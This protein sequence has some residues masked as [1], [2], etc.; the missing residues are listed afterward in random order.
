MQEVC[1]SGDGKTPSARSASQE[2]WEAGAEIEQA[3]RSCMDML[4][5][6]SRPGG[7]GQASMLPTASRSRESEFVT[8]GMRSPLVLALR[9]LLVLIGLHLLSPDPQTPPVHIPE[10]LI[11][12]CDSRPTDSSDPGLDCLS[13]RICAGFTYTCTLPLLYLLTM[14]QV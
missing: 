12:L 14:W 9:V 10:S 1:A 6:G 8:V 2:E 11:Y 13:S 4:D 5:V 7:T 3:R